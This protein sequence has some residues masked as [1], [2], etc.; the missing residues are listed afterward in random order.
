MKNVYA[1]VYCIG[2]MIPS[3][4][5]IVFECPSDLKVI[6]ISEDMS[7]TSLRIFFLHQRVL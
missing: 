4:E 5:W 1:L 3:Y 2:E 7:L 6:T